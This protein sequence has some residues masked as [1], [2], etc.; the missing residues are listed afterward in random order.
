M[1]EQEAGVE[2]RCQFPCRLQTE[3]QFR[4]RPARPNCTQAPDIVQVFDV[5][6]RFL[7]AGRRFSP[8]PQGDGDEPSARLKVTAAPDL[9]YP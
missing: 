6:R 1:N 9:G 3:G 7:A 2:F 8:C 4:C 5:E